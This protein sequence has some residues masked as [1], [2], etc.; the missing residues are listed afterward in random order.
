MGKSVGQLTLRFGLI[1]GWL[2]I[3][4]IKKLL[5]L[6]FKVRPVY[7]NIKFVD[8]WFPTTAPRKNTLLR[9]RRLF[10]EQIINL[11]VLKVEQ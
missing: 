3:V 4:D 9:V 11:F 5:I 7:K 8:Q 10:P 2:L 1:S 6:V